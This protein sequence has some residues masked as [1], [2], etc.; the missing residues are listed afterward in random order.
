MLSLQHLYLA[1]DTTHRPPEPDRVMSAMEHF[2]KR[3]RVRVSMSS[4]DRINQ[5]R[6][7]LEA[8]DRQGWLRSYHQ[9]VTTTHIAYPSLKLESH[10]YLSGSDI[11]VIYP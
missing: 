5:C 1:Y 3:R 2:C 8:L 10:Y 7:G 6:R 9:H 11:A 4:F